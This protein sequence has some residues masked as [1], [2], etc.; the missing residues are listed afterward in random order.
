MRLLRAG[1][2][3]AASSLGLGEAL[4]LGFPGSGVFNNQSLLN[5]GNRLQKHWTEETTILKSLP[6]YIDCS[7]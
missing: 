2:T 1:R 6:L 5:L 7:A 4:W 3:G